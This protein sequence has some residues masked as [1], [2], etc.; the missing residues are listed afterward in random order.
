MKYLPLIAIIA[1]APTLT[2]AQDST[3]VKKG[4]KFGGALPAIA[5]NTDNG[6]RYGVLGNVYD[7]GDGSDYPN[8]RKSYTWNGRVP[9]RAPAKT[10]SSTKTT[11]SSAQICT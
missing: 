6:F 2:L 9:P 1:L 10:I 7:Y 11:T 8:Y 3:N 4:W 5:Y